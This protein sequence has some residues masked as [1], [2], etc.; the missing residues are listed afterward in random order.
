MKIAYS[1]TALLH[2]E[3]PEGQGTKARIEAVDMVL[4]APGT[5]LAQ[6]QL[7]DGN[8]TKQ[9]CHAATDA[10]VQGIISNLHY[11]HQKGHWKSHEHYQHILAMLEKG[12][13]FAG[14]EAT[15]GEYGERLNSTE[16]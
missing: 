2:L 4:D 14:A 1:I 13:A 10:L 12:F 5:M 9:G 8:F 7:P 16:P 15:T 11:A 3:L 6:L